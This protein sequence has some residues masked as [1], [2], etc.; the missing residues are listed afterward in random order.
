MAVCRRAPGCD[1]RA[2]ACRAPHRGGRSA[3]A[4]PESG[5][6][7]SY[8][9]P[10]CVRRRRAA[11]KAACACR[12][13][14]PIRTRRS[15]SRA[16]ARPSKCPIPVLSVEVRHEIDGRILSR[17]C[18][19][20]RISRDASLLLRRLLRHRF[21]SRFRNLHERQLQAADHF[22]SRSSS[23][24]A[25][26]PRVFSRSASSMSITSRAPSRS[27]YACPVCGSAMPPSIAAALRV[28]KSTSI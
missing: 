5:N 9:S 18:I 11:P 25:R 3:R 26:F 20:A 23:A 28:R 16:W 14:L 1:R 21:G 27:T 4:S 2:R 17:V 22:H 15:G 19:L 12:A 8:R 6:P 13:G 10:R 24:F 7:E